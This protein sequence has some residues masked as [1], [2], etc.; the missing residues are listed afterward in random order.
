MATKF[1][2][3]TETA[4]Q[5]LREVK[6]TGILLTVLSPESPKNGS[7]HNRRV[8]SFCA[9]MGAETSFIPLLGHA[10]GC[11]ERL[12]KGSQ[13]AGETGGRVSM[14]ELKWWNVHWFAIC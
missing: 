11:C 4:S 3:H 8:D 10:T 5:K 12:D 1:E 13:I 7:G 2:L 14:F 9:F 6:N